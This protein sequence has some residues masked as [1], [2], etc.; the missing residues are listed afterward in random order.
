VSIFGW[1]ILGGLAG[2]IASM[3]MGTSDRQGC[4]TDIILGVVGAV[5]G[6]F[7]FSIISGGNWSTTFD[8]GSLVVAVIGACIVIAVKRAATGSGKV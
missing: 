6:G 5:I 1:I 8:L 3:I 2:W 4:I 7:L